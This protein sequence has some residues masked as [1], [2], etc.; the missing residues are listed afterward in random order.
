M[1]VLLDIN[2]IV[3]LLLKRD[4]YRDAKRIYA[5][6]SLFS[7][8]MWMAASSVD[9]LYYVLHSEAKRTKHLANEKC[10]DEDSKEVDNL[11]YN[12]MDK[13]SIFSVGPK[14]IRRALSNYK[15]MENTIIYNNFKRIA[16]AGLIISKDK[17]FLELPDVISPDEFIKKYSDS[18]TQPFNITSS[19][20]VHFLDLQ[21]AI[22]RAGATPVFVDIVPSTYNL[23]PSN[24][25]SPQGEK[26]KCLKS[27]TVTGLYA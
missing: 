16:P 27:L 17:Y 24:G 8:K 9:N 13:V 23:D 19:N 4:G 26:Q 3:D 10:A 21:D 14:S 1:D 12:F 7:S 2:I 18:I 6:A 22:L 5:I 15:D 11:F 20:F 25:C